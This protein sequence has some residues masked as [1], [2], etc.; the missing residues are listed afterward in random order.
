MIETMPSGMSE[1]SEAIAVDML[2]IKC[3]PAPR[4][5]PGVVVNG[6]TTGKRSPAVSPPPIGRPPEITVVLPS[7]RGAAM[8]GSA[9]GVV[10]LT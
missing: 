4:P 1:V 6:L 7:A 9:V 5:K 8:P 2:S 10:H 3:T